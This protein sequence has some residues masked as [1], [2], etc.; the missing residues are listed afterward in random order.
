[1][2]RCKKH[3]GARSCDGSAVPTRIPVLL[4]ALLSLLAADA[5]ASSLTLSEYAFAAG[6]KSSENTVGGLRMRVSCGEPAVGEA[7]GGGLQFGAGYHASGPGVTTSTGRDPLPGYAR[8]VGLGPVPARGNVLV[9]WAVSRTS[10]V[11]LGIWDVRGRHVR[12]LLRGSM[13]AGLHRTLW[14][15]RNAAGNRVASGVYFTRLRVD[16]EPVGTRRFVL[17]R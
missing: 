6:S 15:G 8:L 11:S 2:R 17:I 16:G 7:S 3:L 10:D 1:M 9:S 14:D 13:P 4:A 12:T 5:F